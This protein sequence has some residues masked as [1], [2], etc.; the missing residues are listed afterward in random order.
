MH[1]RGREPKRWRGRDK[2]KS[3]MVG[4]P[5]NIFWIPHV[6]DA[7]LQ[8]KTLLHLLNTSSPSSMPTPKSPRG[9]R[10]CVSFRCVEMK[11][12][13]EFYVFRKQALPPPPALLLHLE[14]CKHLRDSQ[15]PWNVVSPSIY[16]DLKGGEAL[17]EKLMC[18]Q[19]NRKAKRGK[20]TD[21]L[22]SLTQVCLRYTDPG[23]QLPPG[24]ELMC[25]STAK[26]GPRLEQSR[27]F[28]PW[29]PD[30]HLAQRYQQTL[31]TGQVM[32]E[33]CL[34]HVIFPLLAGG[35]ILLQIHKPVTWANLPWSSCSRPLLVEW[36]AINWAEI[37]AVP[38]P[39]RMFKPF[40]ALVAKVTNFPHLLPDDWSTTSLTYTNG[41][42]NNWKILYMSSHRHIY[43]LGEVFSP[44]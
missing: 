42:I 23:S 21:I 34:P 4:S 3:S 32:L 44:I 8:G 12:G 25:W 15:R 41:L 11:P 9:V 43:Q 29:L 7:F 16:Q 5:K 27:S 24:L 2:M 35:S 26:A 17:V 19:A 38:C 22:P 13:V 6:L 33:S 30:L 31:T 14:I 40:S 18:K 20:L 1:E 37:M 28:F 10:M 36:K 39:H